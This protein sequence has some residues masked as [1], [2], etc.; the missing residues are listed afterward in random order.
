MAQE[1]TNATS[2]ALSTSAPRPERRASAQHVHRW[3]PMLLG[4]V[5]IVLMLAWDVAAERQAYHGAREQVTQQAQQAADGLAGTITARL[6]SQFTELEFVATGLLVPEV[7]PARL[8]PGVVRALLRFMALH[9]HLYALNL[10][11]PDGN[12]IEW[13]TQVQAR[14]PITAASQFTPLPG[15]PDFLLGQDGY[16]RRARGHVITMRYRV[17]DA[18]GKTRFFVGSPYRLEDL[19]RPASNPTAPSPWVFVVR[20][21]REGSVLGVVHDGRVSFPHRVPTTSLTRALPDRILAVQ[22]GWAPGLVRRVYLDAAFGRWA[23]ELGSW[24]LLLLCLGSIRWLLRDRSRQLQSLLRMSELQDFLAQ[25]NQAAVQESDAQI[26]LQA[27]CDLAIDRGKLALAIVGVPDPEGRVSF[28]ASAGATGY[29]EGLEISVHPEVP[30]GQGPCGH[31]WRS[32]EPI[33]SADFGTSILAP[34]SQRAQRFGLKGNAALPIYRA[35]NRFGVMMLYRRDDV[36]FDVRMQG[37]LAELAADMSRGLDAIDQRQRLELLQRAVDAS[38]DGLIIA[39]AQH[40][41]TFV[42]QGFCAITGYSE[43]EALGRNCKF[44]Q[45]ASTDPA[46]VQRLHEALEAGI[47]FAAELLNVRKDGGLFWNDLRVTP[48]RNASGQLTHFLG[49]QRDI[50]SQHEA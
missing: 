18:S 23:G 28:V 8:N 37:L 15:K 40:N 41:L 39:D 9:P 7:N 29:L 33:F 13:S 3:A 1:A 36:A 20:D 10:Q 12:T 14:A 31:V 45:G 17:R 46:T 21:L 47:P 16:S 2:T 35:G 48:V 25:I 27:V 6:M 43:P 38:S 32:G 11:S 26:F 34:W 4:A 22:V 24:V 44:L 42:S 30:A 19:L 50:T 5:A 49:V